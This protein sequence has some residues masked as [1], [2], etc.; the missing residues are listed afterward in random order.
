MRRG[1]TRCRNP[2]DCARVPPRLKPCQSP[3]AP[4]RRLGLPHSLVRRKRVSRLLLGL[5]LAVAAV[6]P[7]GADTY[8]NH[9]IRWVVGY[10][11]GGTTDIVARIVA[12]HLSQSLGQQVLVDNK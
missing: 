5:L 4:G 10:P 12:Q 11:A 9:P 6:A 7:A 3:I 2:G 8:P 1:R